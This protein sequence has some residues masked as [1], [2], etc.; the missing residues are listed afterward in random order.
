MLLSGYFSGRRAR[1]G[2]ILLGLLLVADLGRADLPWVVTWN[3]V[4]K[5]ATNPVIE[6][7]REKPYEHRVAVLPFSA[8]QQVSLFSQLYDIEWKQQLFQYYNI[9]SLDI[10]MMRARQWTTSPSKPSCFFDRT[11]NTVHR[12]T[13]P[14]A[15]YQY[16]VSARMG[17]VPDRAQSTD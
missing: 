3:W 9:Q 4:Q 6:M 5:Y 14:L 17:R 12:I 8:P 1:V 16:S 10:V 15:A 11:T 13:P 7:L 2:A